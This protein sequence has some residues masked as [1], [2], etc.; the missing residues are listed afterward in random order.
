MKRCQVAVSERS[1]AAIDEQAVHEVDEL[2]ARGAGDRQILAQA[3]VAGEDLLDHEVDRS[4]V[5]RIDLGPLAAGAFGQHVGDARQ[6]P[7]AIAARVVHAV[8]MV[9]TDA[10]QLAVGDQAQQQAMGR[11]EHLAALHAQ[12]GE[13]VDVEE[14]PVVDLGARDAPVGEPVGLVLEQRVQRLE[15]LGQAGR[16]VE[17]GDRRLQRVA[18]VG[19]RPQPRRAPP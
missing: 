4:A 8:D 15:G 6:Q 17:R 18:H 19:D 11:L 2:V 16:A 7:L 1:A 9:E 10:L 12:P 3:L 14:A 13:L 5:A